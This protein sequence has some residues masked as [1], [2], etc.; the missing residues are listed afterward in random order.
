MAN[1]RVRWVDVE[2]IMLPEPRVVNKADGH[3]G[4]AYF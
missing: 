4:A 3:Q 2:I 1:R